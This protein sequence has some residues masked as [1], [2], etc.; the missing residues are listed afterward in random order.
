MAVGSS[1][2]VG[3]GLATALDLSRRPVVYCM[4]VQFR[5]SSVVISISL[6]RCP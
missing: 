2:C 4:A 1:Y 3:D 5:L 6:I